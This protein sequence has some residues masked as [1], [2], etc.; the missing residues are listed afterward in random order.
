[1]IAEGVA[2]HS[3]FEQDPW[4]RLHGTIRTTMDLVFGDGPAANRAV[5]RLNSVHAKVRGDVFDDEARRVAWAY[6]ALDP[7]LLLWVQATLIVTSV[8]AYQRWVAPLNADEREQFWQEA[9]AVGVRLGIPLSLSPQTWPALEAYWA[10]MLAESG[11]VHVTPTARRMARLIVRP[12]FPFVPGPLV[13]LA[14]L[15]GL[16]LLP[17]RIRREFDIPWSAPKQIL[18]G[19][20]STC[21]RAWTRVVPRTLRSMPQ[22]VA[23]DRRVRRAAGAAPRVGTISGHP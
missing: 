13:D 9:R 10:T 3:S 5:K 1:M 16:T 8:A 6:R 4:H 22:A 19:A 12:P 17:P 20:L 2:H 14:A 7:A 11:P 18:A 21:V 23:A 15:P